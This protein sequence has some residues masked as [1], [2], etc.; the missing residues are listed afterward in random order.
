MSAHHPQKKVRY[1]ALSC[2]ITGREAALFV[3]FSAL[4]AYEKDRA[5]T[6]MLHLAFRVLV[7]GFRGVKGLEFGSGGLGFGSVLG[8]GPRLNYPKP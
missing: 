7:F 1:N 4:R 5:S 8:F 3:Q 2:Y 6:A